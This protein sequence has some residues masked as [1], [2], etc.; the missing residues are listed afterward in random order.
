MIA[1]IK[2]LFCRNVKQADK[3]VPHVAGH[4]R[5]EPFFDCLARLKF[6][7]KHIVDIGAN[8]GN[9]TRT[10]LRFFPDAN[11]T[12]FE[13]QKNLASSCQDL[14]LNPKIQLHH[15]GVGP[16]NGLMKLTDHERDDS[17]SFALSEEEAAQQGRKQLEVP[18]VKL[19][20]FLVLQ[21]LTPPDMLKID[22]EGWDLEVLKGAEFSV[23][24]ADI[25]LL[26]ASVMNKFFPNKLS[27]VIAEMEK[28]GFVVFDITD[29]N[30]TARDNALWLV[31]LAFVKAG[32]LFDLNI[33]SYE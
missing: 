33:D 15:L 4:A 19:D 24:R 7:P 14:L 27:Q 2:K 26:E 1:S 25:V 11:F 13:P 31:E 20:D 21:G 18:V 6:N 8:K 29:F 12:M 3:S 28:R 5:T 30:R 23:S 17:F 32:G 22:A 10:A 9:W 16:A